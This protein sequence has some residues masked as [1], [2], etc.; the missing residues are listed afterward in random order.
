MQIKATKPD[1]NPRAV[2]LSCK[3]CRAKKIKCDLQVPCGHCIKHDRCC[4]PTTSDLRRKNYSHTYV[5][6]LEYRVSKLEHV[7]KKLQDCP[8]E[9]HSPILNSLNLSDL[10]SNDEIYPT[11]SEYN[12]TSSS[13]DQS[14][15]TGYGPLSVYYDKIIETVSASYSEYSNSLNDTI[16]LKKNLG[17]CTYCSK[18]LVYSIVALSS[19]ISSVQQVESESYEYYNK[20]RRIVFDKLNVPKITT[21]QTLLCLAFYDLGE[22][23]N[24]SAWL[25]SGIAFRMGIDIG[26]QLNP[27]N[28]HINNKDVLSAQDIE[29]RKRIYW[30]CYTADHFISLLLGRPCQLRLSISTIPHSDNLPLPKNIESFE[31]YDPSFRYKVALPLKKNVSMLSLSAHYFYKIFI[32]KKS[33]KINELHEY[34][35]EI[36]KWRRE[37]PETLSWNQKNLKSDKYD[38]CVMGLRYTYYIM[39]L[40]FNRPFLSSS[41]DYSNNSPML[42]CHETIDDL[43]IV[44]LKFLKDFNSTEKTS[45]LITYASIM[46]I[47]VILSSLEN[48][49]N[50]EFDIKLDLFPKILKFGNWKLSRKSFELI[51]LNMNN[52]DKGKADN[53]RNAHLES[54]DFSTHDI[55]QV[56]GLEDFF[57]DFAIPSLES[58]INFNEDLFNINDTLG[59]ADLFD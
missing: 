42:I 8:L 25:L 6:S 52:P 57:G 45:L 22:G 5:K 33:V 58:F 59:F 2:K 32:D 17:T 28:W 11:L 14:N 47:S 10:A 23:D 49:P 30:G 40:C 36:M 48:S 13:V 39:L 29:I 1:R 26:F 3:S 12:E 37:L 43:Y 31:F 54:K 55:I 50:E 44:I 20:A 4:E 19:K 41:R 24:S 27:Q 53:N 46:S 21:I 9:D 18:E 35:H 15:L 56:N 16:K 51:S 38:P 34:N 7:L